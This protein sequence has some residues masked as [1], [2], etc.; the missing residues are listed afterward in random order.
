L[1]A[2]PTPRGMPIEPPALGIVI[3]T[4]NSEAFVEHALSSITAATHRPVQVVVVDN[5]STDGTLDLVRR[6]EDVTLIASDV[7]LGFAKACNLGARSLDAPYLLFLNPDCVLD[8]GSID[9]AMDRLIHDPTIGIV[10]ARTRHRD[11]A[12]NITCCFAEPTVWSALCF[13]TGLSSA[14]RTVRFFNPEQIGGW[15]R[16]EDRDV[17]VVTGCFAMTRADLFCALGGFD[18][19]FVLY[20]EDTDLS[21]RVR[22]VGLR[23]THVRQA[24]LVHVGGG[25]EPVRAAKV[26]KLFASRQKYYAKYWSP[27]A[28]RAG[29]ALTDLGVLSRYAVTSLLPVP[30]TVDWGEVWKS[31]AMWH[32]SRDRRTEP[33]SSVTSSVQS[34]PPRVQ[35]PVILAPK[36]WGTRARIGYRLV[37]HVVRSTRSRDLDFVYQGLRGLARLPGLTVADLLRKP[38]VECNVCG[39]Q[40]HSFYRNTGPGYDDPRVTCPGCSSLD[41]HR[42]L[43]A[44]IATTTSM[45]DAGVR[46]VEVAPMRGFEEVMRVQPGIDY[47]SFD[48]ERRAM[49]HGDITAMRYPDMS[50]DYFMCFHV[51]E[52]L[53][54]ESAALGEIHRVLRPGAT[55]IF[56]VPI[57]WNS[58]A[59]KEYE[60]PDPRDVGHVRRHGRDFGDRLV[61]A[62]FEVTA[63]R[64]LDVLPPETVAHYGLSAEPIFFGRKPI[65]A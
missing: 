10:G 33:P 23:C 50:V 46:V 6:F 4:Y 14:L 63:I 32:G 30:A 22:A 44:L 56:Q 29:V 8:P 34:R 3:V 7:N 18:E 48:L 27:S 19:R 36:P 16:N 39:W 64:A 15:D 40:G 5:A 2:D 54:D 20:S 24:G 13:A 35:P 58:A 37:R 59:T 25:S 9:V 60:A 12:V 21:R 26:V 45:F 55:A 51:L 62:G 52:H 38:R 49:E 42:T 31:R 17:E 47:V 11:G 1:V 61:A 43:M 28:A 53:P 65:R 57:D 41:R